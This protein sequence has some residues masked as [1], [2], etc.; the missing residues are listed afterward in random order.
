MQQQVSARVCFVHIA[1]DSDG[2]RHH[3]HRIECV[4]YIYRVPTIPRRDVECM[5]TICKCNTSRSVRHAE[6][7][8]RVYTAVAFMRRRPNRP[9]ATISFVPV[10]QMSIYH[11]RAIN[12]TRAT[13]GRGAGRRTADT[14]STT[15]CGASTGVCDA[16]HTDTAAAVH[17]CTIGKCYTHTHY[18]L[19]ACC[20]QAH[21]EQ[22][23]VVICGTPIVEHRAARVI[24]VGF[25][26]R[27]S[28]PVCAR[29]PP[30]AYTPPPACTHLSRRKS[31]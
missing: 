5:S 12:R 10:S 27:T 26:L 14:R 2:Y 25:S 20:N 17:A 16:P 3:Q 7:S 9:Q 19:H 30:P 24:C 29:A 31:R 15:R 6:L 22:T 21:D 13:R 18:T 28:L 1:R 11:A 4:L 8:L 23:C